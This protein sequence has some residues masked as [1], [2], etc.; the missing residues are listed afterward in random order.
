MKYIKIENVR[1][2]HRGYNTDTLSQT[3]N[4]SELSSE[5]S[6]SEKLES[7]LGDI[8]NHTTKE[9]QDYNLD[10]KDNDPDDNPDDDPID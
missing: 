5:S 4:E 3:P 8:E 6:M 10:D 7:M 9:L 1:K 2:I